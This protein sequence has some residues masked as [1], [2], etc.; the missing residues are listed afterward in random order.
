MGI[1]MANRTYLVGL[2]EDFFE[3]DDVALNMLLEAEYCI[4]LFWLALFQADDIRLYHGI[5]ILLTSRQQAL[6]NID[7]RAGGLATLLGEPGDK[8]IAQL[9]AFIE[10]NQYANYLVNTAELAQMEDGEGEFL[11]E[12]TGWFS[13]MAAICKGAIPDRSLKVLA[14]AGPALASFPYAGSP[15]HLCGHS[16]N[17]PLPWETQNV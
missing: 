15:L 8:L 17:L 11:A 14:Q 16:F 1:T 4:P 9:R 5:P 12:L 2:N 6:D 7:Q 10:Q 3:D 13:D